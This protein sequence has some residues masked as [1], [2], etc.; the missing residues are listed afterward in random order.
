MNFHCDVQIQACTNEVP[1][2]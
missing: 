2:N 1:M